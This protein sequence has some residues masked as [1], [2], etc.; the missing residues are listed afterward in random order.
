[1]NGELINIPTKSLDD[2]MFAILSGELIDKYVQEI[3]DK[4]Q[5]VMHVSTADSAMVKVGTLPS[6]GECIVNRVF[7]LRA[8]H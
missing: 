5:I 7:S 1:M 2:M 4:E 6:G 8:C 3:V